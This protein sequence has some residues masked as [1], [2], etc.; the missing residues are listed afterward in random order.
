MR[1]RTISSP[2]NISFVKPGT[3]LLA[4]SLAEMVGQILKKSSVYFTEYNP[5]SHVLFYVGISGA[6]T[7]RVRRM[8]R[9]SLE[10]TP[11][12]VSHVRVFFAANSS[13]KYCRSAFA[14]SPRG[15][16]PLMGS[17]WTM[18]GRLEGGAMPVWHGLAGAR[19]HGMILSMF[20]RMIML[21]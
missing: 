2:V 6:T 17:M 16:A 5:Q 20:A 4:A 21:Q 19:A 11:Q 8:S 13:T 12:A 14:I 3:R 1:L 9:I 10:V 15:C 18:H 7:G